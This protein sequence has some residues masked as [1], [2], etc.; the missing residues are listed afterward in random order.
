MTNSQN[1]G[2]GTSGDLRS[3]NTPKFQTARPDTKY[4]KS[5]L[6]RLPGLRASVIPASRTFRASAKSGKRLW[7]V[8]RVSLGIGE[9]EIGFV[10]AAHFVDL[11]FE[12]PE[13]EDVP[14]PAVLV[15]GFAEDA[16]RLE[17]VAPQRVCAQAVVLVH[18]GLDAP[19]PEHIDSIVRD[20]LARLHAKSAPDRLGVGQHHL[21]EAVPLQKV[22]VEQARQPDRLRP[23]AVGLDHEDDLGRIG[24]DR[25]V[26]GRVLVVDVLVGGEELAPDHP[27]DERVL[28]PRAGQSSRTLPVSFGLTYASTVFLAQTRRLAPL[29][30]VLRISR[31]VNPACRRCV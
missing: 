23:A 30:K 14:E 29:R 15:A 27:L 25:V 1:I 22:D 26:E 13:H 17:P 2:V 7:S 12:D 19:E 18:L 11:L 3:M 4:A 6:S 28:R 16:L 8:K 31:T 10:L 20:E 9:R 24:Q 5:R 21:E